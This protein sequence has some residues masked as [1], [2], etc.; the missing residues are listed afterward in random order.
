[1]FQYFDLTSERFEN[2]VIEICSILFGM[3]I[4]SYTAGR[5]RGKDAVFEGTANEF[6]NKSNPWT[7]KVVIQ[8]KHTYAIGQYFGDKKFVGN[9][10]S[11]ISK[12]IPKIK[13]MFENN[14]LD[15]YIIFSN[16]HLTPNG[17]DKVISE[18]SKQTGLPPQNIYLV[19]IEYLDRFLYNHYDI[20]TLPHIDLEPLNASPQIELTDIAEVIEN[21]AYESYKYKN[22][23]TF[24]NDQRPVNRTNFEAKNKLNNLSNAYAQLLKKTY[25]QEMKYVDQLLKDPHNKSI[26]SKY[27]NTIMDLNLK[28]IL[29][30]LEKNIAFDLILNKIFDYFI[31]RNPILKQHKDLT[32]MLLFYMYWNCDIGKSNDN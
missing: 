17:E 14:E 16:R 3:G 19:G 23:N 26:K 7:G 18:I 13:R 4:R 30:D 32:R 20:V 11:V 2:L 8:A 22:K 21:L 25:I 29:H 5:D 9:K 31:G 1:M 28:I 27:Q 6:P 24:N 12:E 10:S 15:Y